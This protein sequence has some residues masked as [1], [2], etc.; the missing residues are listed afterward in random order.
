MLLISEDLDELLQLSDRILVIYGGS[1]IGESDHDQADR[2]QIG[3]MMAGIRSR[4]GSA[5]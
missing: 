2:E 5:V 4:E 3:L 1:I